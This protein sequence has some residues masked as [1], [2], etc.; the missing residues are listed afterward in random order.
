MSHLWLLPV[1]VR[2]F[3]LG[4]ES[5]GTRDYI[6][7]SQ[8]RDFL[9]VASYYSLGYCG[10]IRPHLH[11]GMPC[12]L[13]TNCPPYNISAPTAQKAPFLCCCLQL[14]L[15]KYACLRSSCSVTVVVYLLICRSLLSNDSVCHNIIQCYTACRIPHSV[16]YG[17]L[18]SVS[19]T[20]T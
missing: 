8:S 20:Y 7:L 9:F 14:L 13:S 5:P 17:T 3:V 10:G 1:L 19:F 6:L 16:E 18:F 4:S 12:R 11:M 15:R 2:A